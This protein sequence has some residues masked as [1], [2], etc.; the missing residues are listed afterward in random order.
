MLDSKDFSF[1][2]SQ[3][4]FDFKGFLIKIAS[5][6]KWFLASL[7]ISFTIAHQVNIRKEKIYQMETTIAVKEQNNPWS[8]S[9]TSL[10]F[11][12]GGTSDQ[13]QNI[14]STI[15]SRSHNEKVV[16]RLDYYI[17]YLQ[18]YEYYT[19]DVYGEV[20]FRV[21]VDSSR[22]NMLN[23]R[24]RIKFIS[25]AEYEIHTEFPIGSLKC[26]RYA[27]SQ[28]DYVQVGQENFTR[29]YKV[30]EFTNVPFLNFK[31]EIVGTPG[32]YTKSEY[33]I[34]FR[35]FNEAVSRYR[36]IRTDISDKSPS[37]IRL[38]LEGTNKARMVD[39]L[40]ATVVTLIQ[41]QLDR[42]NQFANN[43]IRFIDST[44]NAMGDQ[45][46]MSEKELQDFSSRKN[47]IALTGGGGELSTRLSSLDIE[48]DNIARKIAYLNNLRNYLKSSTD[49]SKLPAP[50]VGGIEDPNI[51]S[52]VAKIVEKS[53]ERSQK[54]YT[55][56]SD[57]M[58]RHFDKDI[59]AL[60]LVL[61][62]NINTA[63]AGLNYDMNLVNRNIAEVESKISLLP[64]DQQEY[65][66]IKRKYD[67][68]ENVLIAMQE[69]LKQAQILRASNI[70]D[71]QFI[72]P[73]K[74]IGET[75]GLIGPNTSV[76]YIMAFFLG[77]LIPLIIVFGI[78][79]VE[80][81]ILNIEDIVKL[82][83]VPIIGVVGLKHTSSNLSVFE[84][85]KSALAESFRAI[86]SSL[87]FLYKKNDRPGAKTLMLTSSISGEGKTF[88]S[89]NIAT[90]FAMS[91]KKVV[92]VGFDL[93]KPK[94]FDDFNV[95]RDIGV[96]NYLIGQ[97]TLDEV[98]Q[99]THV[100]Y[101]DVVASGPI[102]PNPSELIISDATREMMDELRKRYDYIIVD[103]SPVGL[104][105]DAIELSQYADLTLYVMRQNYTKKEMITLMNNRYKRG[106]LSNVSIVFNGYQNKAKYGSGYGY[107]YG[108]SYGY[109]YGTYG[110]GYHDDNPPRNIF[111]KL[112]RKFRRKS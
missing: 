8:T 106:E 54:A 100:P 91:E 82:T 19:R 50:A 41:S 105:S 95:R 68:N 75:A 102:P 43:T 15:K 81:A 67:L 96:V 59:Q 6:W 73:A 10:V 61:L 35:D 33:F 58:F 11:N 23:R 63:A 17:D 37:I 48:K 14:S 38:S 5:Y 39:Y 111:E 55:N 2:E 80:N 99:P 94:I 60:K 66:K 1:L 49:F 9:N 92:I 70:S 65:Y 77:L 86:R 89:I 42:K 18:D 85:P 101:L 28:L 36:S 7:I 83:K 72:D 27:D 69:K 87:Q 74:D 34:R 71:I 25:A 13:V 107:G 24:I 47:V 12:W 29:R 16:D 103:T 93:R 84:R 62:E 64:R 26:M 31:L 4:N 22:L 109:G 112:Y 78:F 3:N 88:C 53:V 110:H 76:N 90:V 45:I 44:L 104:V 98:I 57:L 79:F 40:N 108:Y 32:D 46:K 30:G 21:V 51:V 56:K 97:K 20:P 52:N